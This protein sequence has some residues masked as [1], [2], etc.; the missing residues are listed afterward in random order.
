MEADRL[1]Y[2]W[3][4]LHDQNKMTPDATMYGLSEE[5]KKILEKIE[6]G[7][8]RSN[9]SG[10][11][12]L[13]VINKNLSKEQHKQALLKDKK[14]VKQLGGGDYELGK[15]K[16]NTLTKKQWYRKTELNEV[17]INALRRSGYE[18]SGNNKQVFD[19]N[20]TLTSIIAFRSGGFKDKRIADDKRE[21][22][23]HFSKSYFFKEIVSE[24]EIEPKIEGTKS[25]P[26]ASITL[27]NG[28]QLIFEFQDAVLSTNDLM[29]KIN[30]LKPYVD[31]IY[32]ICK[33]EDLPIFEKVKG[34]DIFVTY[35]KDFFNNVVPKIKDLL[36]K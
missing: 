7:A 18:E 14:F 31:K 33:K 32:I 9:S 13:V 2:I 19:F 28:E 3:K 4:R 29:I 25:R 16:L 30:S 6:T 35:N 5:E 21:S 34:E 17:E 24:V 26:D 8:Y 20:K 36:K 23:Q 11:E 15:K 22:M 27:P 1:F 10:Q 12:D